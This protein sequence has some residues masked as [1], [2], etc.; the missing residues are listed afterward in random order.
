MS[1]NKR[2]IC[3]QTRLIFLEPFLAHD[4]YVY[5]K[6]YFESLYLNKNIDDIVSPTTKEKIKIGG[7][8]YTQL[9]DEIEEF[10]K[11][12][13]NYQSDRNTSYYAMAIMF[14]NCL[15]FYTDC[16]DI[17]NFIEKGYHG[18]YK[19]NIS[20]F[21]HKNI[22]ID[23]VNDYELLRMIIND[24][25]FNI[26]F[27]DITDKISFIIKYSN[28]CVEIFSTIINKDKDNIKIYFK[29]CCIY[30]RYDLILQLDYYYHSSDL[31]SNKY[32]CENLFQIV[33]FK[34]NL[35]IKMKIKILKFLHSKN[36]ELYKEK[37]LTN[38][39]SIIEEACIDGDFEIVKFIHIIDDTFYSIKYG[40]TSAFEYACMYGNLEIAM[41]LYSIDKN[42]YNIESDNNIRMNIY[43]GEEEYQH[44]NMIKKDFHKL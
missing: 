15:S 3:E 14:D 21:K 19:F 23:M 39:T 9:L 1:I 30:G 41:F 24:N 2:F 10:L 34:S 42:V 6:E 4:G 7:I 22:L 5:E 26:N 32:D 31:T 16:T 13:I 27:C 36:N 33:C 44:Y 40:R 12:N 28:I 37:M 8:I 29:N 20:Q 43:V 35:E 17:H 38:N 11:I 18:E 25:K